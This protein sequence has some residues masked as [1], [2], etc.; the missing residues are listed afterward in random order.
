MENFVMKY[1]AIIGNRYAD[2]GGSSST[3]LNARK[4]LGNH[5]NNFAVVV[6]LKTTFICHVN[7][8]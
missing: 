8:S 2:I 4:S 1:Q 3:F 5:A 6:V 7:G